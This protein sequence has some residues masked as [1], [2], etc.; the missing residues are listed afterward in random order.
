M[1]GDTYTSNR[2]KWLEAIAAN[3]ALSSHAARVA[4]VI[5]SHLSRTKG[6]AWPSIKTIAT[7][8][9]S[10]PRRV[11]RAIAE[12]CNAGYLERRRRGFSLSNSYVI[13]ETSPHRCAVDPVSIPAMGG[14]NGADSPA[15]GGGN[16][17]AI[18]ATGGGSVPPPVADHSR[19]GWRTNPL[20][21][22]FEDNPKEETYSQASEPKAAA[23][24]RESVKPSLDWKP[25]FDEFWKQYPRK[26]GRGAA[27][28]AYRA[29]LKIVSAE[30]LMAACLRFSAAEDAAYSRGKEAQYTPHASTWLNRRSWEDEPDPVVTPVHRPASSNADRKAVTADVAQRLKGYSDKKRSEEN[31]APFI[32]A[33][34][35]RVTG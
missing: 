4:I 17:D 26:K 5:S 32:E 8:A 24:A 34:L 23:P 15:M 21:E 27:E 10:P 1:S 29:A 14:G 31:R 19:H 9:G 16:E 7:C 3:D 35:L 20:N 6:D 33:S 11:E 18:P 13:P 28:K 12:L 25:D 30:T 2:F 22:P